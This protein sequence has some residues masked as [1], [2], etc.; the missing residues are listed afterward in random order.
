[1]KRN[2]L[3]LLL[4]G[5]LT[6]FFTGVFYHL[7][8]EVSGTERILFQHVDAKGDDYGPGTYIY[9]TH[10]HFEPHEDLFDLH[11]F[12]VLEVGD[13]YHFLISF[14]KITNPWRARYGF[15]HQLIQ[16]YIDNEPGG[17][18]TTLIPGANVTFHEENPWNYLIKASGWGVDLY[19]W[20]EDPDEVS[21]EEMPSIHL[22]E[23]DTILIEVPREELGTLDEALYY[24]LSG[25]FDVFGKDNFREV[26]EEVATWYLGGGSDSTFNPNVLDILTPESIC[27][28]EMLGNWSEEEERLALIYPV[29][30]R[31]DLLSF[32][33]TAGIFL[34][35][36]LSLILLLCLKKRAHHW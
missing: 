7:N 15:S 8:T 16:I 23:R 2:I 1:M 3:L 29:G 9:P 28:K 27:Q 36:I 11:R 10:Q 24:V 20:E 34:L 31:R 22:L 6:G 30:D 17:S 21:R 32:L 18:L 26:R 5:L 33:R 14:G 13:M 4:L 25:S 12:K 35:F 19:H